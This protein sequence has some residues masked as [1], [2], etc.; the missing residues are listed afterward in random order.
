M[1]QVPPSPMISIDDENNPKLYEAQ[2]SITA[3]TA[4]PVV[5]EDVGSL[6]GDD[7]LKLAGTHAH[8]FDEKYYLRLRR[9]IVSHL[10]LKH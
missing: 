2:A 10:E 8:Q 6:D 3:V 4:M 7:A 1:T 5:E 9:K